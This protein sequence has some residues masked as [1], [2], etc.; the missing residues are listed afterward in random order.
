MRY[1]PQSIEWLMAASVATIL[2][3]LPP[4]HHH[5]HRYGIRPPSYYAVDRVLYLIVNDTLVF[6]L[7]VQQHPVSYNRNRPQYGR[8]GPNVKIG[9]WIR[10]I[11]HCRGDRTKNKLK[12][13]ELEKVNFLTYDVSWYWSDGVVVWR[14]SPMR[15]CNNWYRSILLLRFHRSIGLPDDWWILMLLLLLW[16][17]DHWSNDNNWYTRHF[18]K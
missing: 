8:Y 13:N 7:Q 14:M 15:H 1:P 3:I 6:L 9:P 5:H 17:I 12:W 11:V 2:M 4:I 10:Y 16:T 18:Q